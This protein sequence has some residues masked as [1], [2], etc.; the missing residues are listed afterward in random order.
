MPL[1]VHAEIQYK[2]EGED[3]PVT[4]QSD[5]CPPD[6]SNK[7][8]QGYREYLHDCLDEWLDNSDGT[9]IFYITGETKKYFPNRDR[10]EELEYELKKLI[11][12]FDLH[13]NIL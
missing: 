9:G 2:T 5:I 11:L 6:C 13:V 3:G 10:A 8:T 1:Q 4:V 12:K 7:F